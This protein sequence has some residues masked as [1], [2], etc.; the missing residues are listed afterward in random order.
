M[1]MVGRRS[2]C[3]CRELEKLQDNVEKFFETDRDT[4]LSSHPFFR[5]CWENCSL[6]PPYPTTDFASLPHLLYLSAHLYCA[7]T[8]C[9]ST[10][11]LP[12]ALHLPANSWRLKILISIASSWPIRVTC[13]ERGVKAGDICW[14]F[15]LGWK[16]TNCTEVKCQRPLS[17]LQGREGGRSTSSQ[18]QPSPCPW[19]GVH[20]GCNHVRSL[21]GGQSVQCLSSVQLHPVVGRLIT[22]MGNTQVRRFIYS[23]SIRLENIYWELTTYKSC[24]NRYW[25]K[26]TMKQILAG[27]HLQG[28]DLP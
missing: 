22:Y 8:T 6:Q 11:Y 15:Q 26:P 20:G 21:Q 3:R 7:W 1:D 13:R 25:G 14:Y 18:G 12:R 23:P 2:W 4:G 5:W 28:M 10:S 24:C 27:L 19:V 9:I 16:Q 17:I